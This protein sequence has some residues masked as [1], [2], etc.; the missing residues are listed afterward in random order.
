VTVDDSPAGWGNGNGVLDP[1][2]TAKLTVE[3]RNSGEATAFEPVVA[4]TSES[5]GIMIHEETASLP[6]L[7][8]TESGMSTGDGPT[9]TLAAG[10]DCVGTL[11]FQFEFVDAAGTTSRDAWQPEVGYALTETILHDDFE[12]DMGWIFDSEP[13]SGEWERGDPVGSMDGSSQANPESDSPNDAGAQCYVTENGPPGGDPDAQDVDGAV[14]LRSPP[15]DFTGYK[16]ARLSFDLWYYDNSSSAGEDYAQYRARVIQDSPLEIW[17]HDNPTNG[18]L[19]KVQDLTPYIPMVP[20]IRVAFWAYDNTPDSIAEMGV[21]NVLIEGDRQVCDNLGIT[22]PPYG[23]GDTLRVAKQAG[24]AEIT[25]LAAPADETHDAPAFYEV[26][27]SPTADA[28]FAVV[29]TTTLTK[30][31]QSLVPATEFYKVSA[32]NA[33]GTSGDEPSP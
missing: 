33:A 31:A 7:A 25:W 13:G 14:G 23:V 10:I 19:S 15:L 18:W 4:I 17:N 20:D 9:V 24:E 12:T 1:G 8:P 28:G 16:R 22:Y 32:V 3:G 2:E 30:V 21:D 11:V 29:D 26:Y 6:D 27:A 5:P